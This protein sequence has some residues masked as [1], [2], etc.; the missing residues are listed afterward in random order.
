MAVYNGCDAPKS[1]GFACPRRSDR[2]GKL[3][4]RLFWQ[5]LLLDFGV[6]RKYLSSRNAGL[7]EE[8]EDRGAHSCLLRFHSTVRMRVGYA[9][10]AEEFLGAGH[11]LVSKSTGR[12]LW[13]FCHY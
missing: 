7:R 1:K 4:L 2:W 3:P 8:G 5:Y 12:H 9:R 10:L 6:V 11:R 13:F